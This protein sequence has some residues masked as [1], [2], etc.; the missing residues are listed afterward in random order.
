MEYDGKQALLPS[1]LMAMLH[2]ENGVLS[3]LPSCAKLHISLKPSVKSSL[4]YLMIRSLQKI[5]TYHCISVLVLTKFLWQPLYWLFIILH[6][7][8]N[9][10]INFPNLCDLHD[11][12]LHRS[13]QASQFICSCDISIIHGIAGQSFNKKSAWKCIY[14]FALRNKPQSN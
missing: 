10:C 5:T 1:M 13:L 14:L 3:N 7:S 11:S 8:T 4:L 9:K 12:W 6:L 2:K